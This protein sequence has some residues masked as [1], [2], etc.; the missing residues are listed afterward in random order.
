M[1]TY[2]YIPGD[3]AI[4]CQIKFFD[5]AF[6]KAGTNFKKDLDLVTNEDNEDYELTD[7]MEI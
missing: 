1:K 7:G 4:E 5:E 2:D 3:E 6:S